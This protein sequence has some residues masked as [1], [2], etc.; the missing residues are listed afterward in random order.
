LRNFVLLLLKIS[1]S[2]EVVINDR[3]KKAPLDRLLVDDPLGKPIY[4][5]NLLDEIF[6]YF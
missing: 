4:T 5:V 2:E 6:C 3:V 1:F